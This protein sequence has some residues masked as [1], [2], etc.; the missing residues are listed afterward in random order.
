M[1]FY[2]KREQVKDV[3]L[4]LRRSNDESS[5][6]QIR[7]IEDQEIACRMLA[8]QLDLNIVEV[9]SESSSAYSPNNRSE[10]DRMVKE[11]SYK[12]E[13]KRRAEG[14]LAWHPNRLSR[15]ALEAG[16]LLQMIDDGFI[17]DLFFCVY[18]FHNDP[19]GKEHLFMEFARAKGYSDKLSEDVNRGMDNRR[20]KG[21]EMH[22]PPFGYKKLR[23][24]STAA[25]S[26]LFLVPHEVNWPILKKIFE[27]R[28]E[29]MSGASIADYLKQHGIKPEYGNKQKKT[30]RLPRKKYYT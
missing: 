25:E 2:R 6:K 28:M 10:F 16:K 29:G 4:Y 15:N 3:F 13:S 20:T 18:M 22:N 1:D 9:F 30:T 19:S 26:S 12:T 21:A 23:E 17:K 5:K 27:L 8:E 7:S 11:L 24:K 14:I